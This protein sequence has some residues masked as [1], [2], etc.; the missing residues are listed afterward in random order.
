MVMLVLAAPPLEELLEL[1]EL[2]LLEDDEELELVEDDEELEL[3]ELGASPEPPQDTNVLTK[4]QAS[5]NLLFSILR[6]SRKF[7]ER[8]DIY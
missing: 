3:L 7:F 4:I 8:F 6:I 2:E 5:N 1:E